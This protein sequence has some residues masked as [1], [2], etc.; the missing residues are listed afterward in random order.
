MHTDTEKEL[1]KISMF[2]NRVL[3]NLKLLNIKMKNNK[4][5]NIKD[6]TNTINIM[7]KWHPACR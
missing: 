1:E 5:I 4:E 6:L 7:N 2:Y 3:E